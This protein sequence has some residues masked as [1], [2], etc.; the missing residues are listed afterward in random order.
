MKSNASSL[1]I[2]F[3]IINLNLNGI[4]RITILANIMNRPI[5]HRFG[6]L[7]VQ[8]STSTDVVI[9]AENEFSRFGWKGFNVIKIY[10]IHIR[11]LLL[12]LKIIFNIT[13]PFLT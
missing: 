13:D 8:Y 4:V 11:F 3:L 2:S 10:H 6:H 1:T 7:L 9:K 5:V 12:Y